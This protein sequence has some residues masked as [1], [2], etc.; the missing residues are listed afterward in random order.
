MA[1]TQL[2]GDF[3]APNAAVFPKMHVAA[4]DTCG[5]DVDQAFSCGGRGGGNFDDGKV[6][7]GV[8]CDGDVG[9]F[10]GRGGHFDGLCKGVDGVVCYADVD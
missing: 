3:R 5:R 7:G 4:A 8:G 10:E 6:V 2:A 1:K 9:L